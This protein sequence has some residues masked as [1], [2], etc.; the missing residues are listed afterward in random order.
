MAALRA[1]V[2]AVARRPGAVV[3]LGPAVHRAPALAALL[4]EPR[5][6]HLCHDFGDDG[7]LWLTPLRTGTPWR[8]GSPMALGEALR[9]TGYPMHRVYWSREPV[10]PSGPVVLCVVGRRITAWPTTLPSPSACIIVESR[11]RADTGSPRA[12]LALDAG[13]A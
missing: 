10:T 6:L 3:M 4:D 8:R 11:R 2:Q 9:A 13:D 7:D 1:A 5:D 12:P